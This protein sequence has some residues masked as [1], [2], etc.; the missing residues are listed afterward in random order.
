M[1]WIGLVIPHIVRFAVG[2]NFTTLLPASMLS[3]A[4]FLLIVDTAARSIIT[5]EIPLGVI[6]SL[7][8]APVFV[9]LLYKSKRGFS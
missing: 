7:I 3:G 5:N 1:S 9:Y 4:L 8:G 2:A 6:T